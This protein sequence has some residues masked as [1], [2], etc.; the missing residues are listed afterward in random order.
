[1]FVGNRL[2]V[3]EVGLQDVEQLARRHLVVGVEEAIAGASDLD[4]NDRRTR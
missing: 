3:P 1:V 4:W 2:E